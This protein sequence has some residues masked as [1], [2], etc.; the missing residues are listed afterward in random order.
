MMGS[1]D[2]GGE[3]ETPFSQILR[4]PGSRRGVDGAA[5]TRG[6]AHSE[7]Q[8][9]DGAPGPPVAIAEDVTV[10]SVS[11]PSFGTAVE[12]GSPKVGG[13]H[14]L[15][16]TGAG[17]AAAS[18]AGPTRVAASPPPGVGGTGGDRGRP[19]SGSSA[20]SAPAE[21]AS[22]D[23]LELPGYEV[24]RF[25]GKGG[26]GEVFLADRL[27]TTGVTVRC[28]VKTI[29]QGIGNQAQFENLFLD[30]ARIVSLL[31]HPNIVSTIDV[32]RAGGRLYLAMEWID[33]VDAGK[34]TK[35]A[36]EQGMGLP[37][38]H[39]LYIL[40][41]TL[42]G[43]HHAHTAVGPDG[44]P[45]R[46]VHRD[47]SQGN[48]L[49][50][51]HGAVKLA[52]F[53]VAVGTAAKTAGSGDALA[54]KPHYFAPELWRGSKASP[55]TDIFALGVTFY[56]LLTSRPLFRRGIPMTALTFEICEFSVESLIERDLTIPDGIEDILFRALHQDP[57]RR[58]A[59]AL[60][61][62]EDVNDYA[63]EYGIRL[64][65]A[66]FGEY[67]ARLLSDEAPPDGRRRLWK[68]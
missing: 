25:F 29:R 15:V 61:F 3:D 26:M 35:L 19:P 58:Y 2:N 42:Q 59:T 1:S 68:D 34:L 33:G 5:E 64:L 23:R 12:P 4:R 24:L 60:E 41:E 55:Q 22:A 38:P 18:A 65:D 56:E 21:D 6:A 50:S 67:V 44:Q 13:D 46:I 62:L 14:V 53:G 66:H 45:L 37:L 20:A 49:I 47:I 7:G 57:E 63:Y 48:I 51:K 39:V 27:S 9:V 16:A 17:S 11:R 30:E 54:G 43:L 52:D 40:R 8:P 31:R 10:D 28:V 36:A 32:G